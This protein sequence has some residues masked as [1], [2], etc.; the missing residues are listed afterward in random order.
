MAEE[1]H[2]ALGGLERVST[3]R[4]HPRLGVKGLPGPGISAHQTGTVQPPIDVPCMR[5]HWGAG[6]TRGPPGARA[7]EGCPS[8]S[9]RF[10]I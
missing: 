4:G 6:S 8:A 2:T 9:P 10:Q 5:A 7:E 1:G 3:G